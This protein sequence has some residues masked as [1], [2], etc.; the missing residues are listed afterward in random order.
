MS[1]DYKIDDLSGDM[2]IS[3][4]TLA[5]ETGLYEVRQR[6]RTR[7]NKQLGEWRYNLASGIPWMPY[8]GEE[9]ILGSKGQLDRARALISDTVSDTDGVTALNVVSVV[10]DT[11]TRN[12]IISLDIATVYGNATIII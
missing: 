9:G 3:G 4:G 1:V 7:V 12:F 2:V 11:A 6:V 8:N 5:E 10:F